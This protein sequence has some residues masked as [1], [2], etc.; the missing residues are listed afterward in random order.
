[1]L[2]SSDF[3]KRML[4]KCSITMVFIFPLL[5]F[6]CNMVNNDV[7]FPFHVFMRWATLWFIRLQEWFIIL[8]TRSCP[9]PLIRPLRRPLALGR[10]KILFPGFIRCPPNISVY[11]V[12]HSIPL[13]GAGRGFPLLRMRREGISHISLVPSESKKLY[14]T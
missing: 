1:M 11:N 3:W 14:C 7:L 12:A 6:L 8:R 10:R 5:F 9:D 13:G 4:L 2:A